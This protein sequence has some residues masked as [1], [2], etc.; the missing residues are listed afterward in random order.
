MT[1]VITRRNGEIVRVPMLSRIDTAAE[2][3]VYEAGGVLQR[4]AQEFLA[5]TT[6]A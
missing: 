6:S 2:Q 1:L 3:V 5:E 4:F